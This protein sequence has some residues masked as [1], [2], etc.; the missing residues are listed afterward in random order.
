MVSETSHVHLWWW[1]H[2]VLERSGQAGLERI[3]DTVVVF[4]DRA[5]AMSN[6]NYFKFQW[7]RNLQ[8]V[9]KSAFSIQ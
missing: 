3:W 7:Y 4:V 8:Y 1:L 5:V 2:K 6:L 9:A